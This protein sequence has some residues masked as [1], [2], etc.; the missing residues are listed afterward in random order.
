V[1]IYKQQKP[2]QIELQLNVFCSTF[3][4]IYNGTFC[5]WC[6]LIWTWASTQTVISNRGCRAWRN[7]WHHTE[8][9]SAAAAGRDRENPHDV[10]NYVTGGEI[11]LWLAGRWLERALINTE[12]HNQLRRSTVELSADAASHTTESC[13]RGRHITVMSHWCED[14]HSVTVTD[15][16]SSYHMLVYQLFFRY[17]MGKLSSAKCLLVWHHFLSYITD[18]FLNQLI[19]FYSN[20][21]INLHHFNMEIVMWPQITVTS[22]SHSL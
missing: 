13:L 1:F 15:V 8:F 6:T 14:M 20:N 16:I 9:P 7:L 11:D 10:R 18:V 2:V 17:D 3:R 21:A 5:G 19:Q 12:W 22:L 4:L